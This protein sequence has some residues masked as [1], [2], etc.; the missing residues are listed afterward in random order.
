MSLFERKIICYNLTLDLKLLLIANC[1]VC[2]AQAIHSI[3]NSSFNNFAALIMF[4]PLSV[5]MDVVLYSKFHI[6]ITIHKLFQQYED[7][8]HILNLIMLL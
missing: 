7:K 8:Q 3:L 2:A 6:L 1:K 5:V 4:D